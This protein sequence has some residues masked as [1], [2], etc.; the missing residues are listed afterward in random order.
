MKKHLSILL[1]IILLL[2][3]GCRPHSTPATEPPTTTPP[4]QVPTASTDNPRDGI[5]TVGI[6][7]SQSV[8]D[9]ENN[10]YT[11]WLEEESG[12]DLHFLYFASAP[13]DYMVQF[14]TA[15]LISDA[16]M[17]N[18]PDILIGFSAM[19]KVKW[20]QYGTEGYLLDLTPYIMDKSGVSKAWWDRAIT[21]GTGYAD[22]LIASCSAENGRVY[23]FP[24]VQVGQ[25][26]S[27]YLHEPFD[28]QEVFI[29]RDAH[30]PDACWD[31]LML[32]STEESALRQ[33]Y[34]EKGVD[35]D[36]SSSQDSIRLLGPKVYGTDNNQCW[37]GIYA[38]ILQDVRIE[39]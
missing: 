13:Q 37:N 16:G 30:D 5:I 25:I 2:C 15:L 36:W 26:D 29:S 38:T 3:A 28:T 22:A 14:A 10:A 35:W 24:T 20:Q 12:Y 11:L 8:T 6:P 18:L 27:I 7:Q 23:A 33:L 1:C 9:Y 32:M 31:L 19:N 17:E 4:T 39:S 21:L 34:G